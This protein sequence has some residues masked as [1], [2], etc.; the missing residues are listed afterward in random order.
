MDAT[1]VKRALAPTGPTTADEDLYLK[2]KRAQRSLEVL[3]IQVRA[4]PFAT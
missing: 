4:P 3:D 1:P 2:L